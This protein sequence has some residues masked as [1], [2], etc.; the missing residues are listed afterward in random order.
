MPAGYPYTLAAATNGVIDAD[1]LQDMSH[2]ATNP[3]WLEI[4]LQGMYNVTDLIFFNR[5][6]YD[7]A[8]QNRIAGGTTVFY[9][10]F[11][12]PVGQLSMLG[13][14]HKKYSVTLFPPTPTASG[15]ASSSATRTQTATQT[16]TP[17]PSV[18]GTGTQTTTPTPSATVSAGAT[19]SITSTG[20]LT[21]SNTPSSSLTS[22]A[23]PSMTASPSQTASSTQTPFSIYPFRVRL[24]VTGQY[25]NF[26]EVSQLNCLFHWSFSGI[27]CVPFLTIYS[28]FQE[29]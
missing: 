9:N 29:P 12:T 19:A 16:N 17:S 2:S 14:Y 5:G 22:S 25:L 15:T 26:Q 10:N 3:G 21:S 13:M 18:T 23:T 27:L 11:R 8:S 20:S 24:S 28:H 1:N 6:P 7:Y 4:D